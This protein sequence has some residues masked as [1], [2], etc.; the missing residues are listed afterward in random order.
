LIALL[1][2]IRRSNLVW[3]TVSATILI[4]SREWLRI[5]CAAIAVATETYDAE[6]AAAYG[7]WSGEGRHDW[8]WWLR[9]EGGEVER[10]NCFSKV[11]D[12]VA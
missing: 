10:R 8:I 1:C 7:T 2:C 6:D 4:G 11:G 5:I 12:C 3:C 9:E